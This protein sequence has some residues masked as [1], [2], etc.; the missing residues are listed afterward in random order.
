MSELDEIASRIRKLASAQATLWQA[1]LDSVASYQGGIDQTDDQYVYGW[2]WDANRGGTPLEVCLS[3]NGEVLLS[4]PADSFR[5][6][7]LQAG[8]GDGRHA[9]TAPIPPQ[10]QDGSAYTVRV[11]VAG[12]EFEIG[13]FQHPPSKHS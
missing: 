13:V 6:D 8:K 2:V 1:R 4:W 7:L 3:E 9:F 12:S 10:L 11:T 5:D